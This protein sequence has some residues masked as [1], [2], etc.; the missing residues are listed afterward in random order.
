MDRIVEAIAKHGN[1]WTLQTNN[2]MQELYEPLHAARSSSFEGSVTSVKGLRYGPSERHR[3]DVR[4]KFTVNNDP[5]L[6]TNRP[7]FTAQ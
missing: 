7:R 4:E 5:D 2:D 6:Y 1:I 3:L